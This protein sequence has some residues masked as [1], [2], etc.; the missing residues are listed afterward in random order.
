M[1]D[2]PANGWRLLKANLAVNSQPQTESTTWETLPVE[3]VVAAQLLELTE[4]ESARR[5]AVHCG[6][7]R[8]L[9]VSTGCIRPMRILTNDPSSGCLTLTYGIHIPVYTIAQQTNRR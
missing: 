3:T 5:F 1:E 9:L 4:R 2:I 8:G 6:E 7:Q